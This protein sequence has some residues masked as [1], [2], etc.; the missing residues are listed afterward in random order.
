M[1]IFFTKN[2]N[3]IKLKHQIG[4]QLSLSKNSNFDKKNYNEMNTKKNPRNWIFTD[5]RCK[6]RFPYRYVSKKLNNSEYFF[7]V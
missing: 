5:L 3:F 7:N 4:S 6:F 1:I 2:I